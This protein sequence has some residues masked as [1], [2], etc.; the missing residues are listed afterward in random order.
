V[1]QAAFTIFNGASGKFLH[2]FKFPLRATFPDAIKIV[3]LR[4]HNAGY[5]ISLSIPPSCELCCRNIV[6][7][8]DVHVET[9]F[10]PSI[11]KVLSTPKPRNLRS[12]RQVKGD[13]NKSGPIMKLPL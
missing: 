8:E 13:V 3:D 5:G 4:D 11:D 12:E 1:R 7:L 2:W 10:L 6:A 9:T